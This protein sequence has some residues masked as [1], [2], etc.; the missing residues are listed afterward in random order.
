MD[1]FCAHILMCAICVLMTIDPDIKIKRRK[2]QV[3]D[4][5]GWKE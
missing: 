2:I 1:K 3:L 4:R 5:F